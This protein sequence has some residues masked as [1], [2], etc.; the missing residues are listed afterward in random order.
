ESAALVVPRA[1][2]GSTVD[3]DLGGVVART[4]GQRTVRHL[5][6]GE[7]LAVGPF[8][9]TAFPFAAEVPAGVA[10]AWNCYLVETEDAVI[11]LCADSAFEEAQ[12]EFLA[13]RL[14]S[15]KRAAL[16]LSRAWAGEQR[17]TPGYR[18]HSMEFLNEY[19]RWGWYCPPIQL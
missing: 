14:G 15:G 1:L 13:E 4:L 18:D 3:V 12:I 5:G 8:E 2:P 19:R 17:P 7:K 16:L 9:I 6:H 11:A 10:H